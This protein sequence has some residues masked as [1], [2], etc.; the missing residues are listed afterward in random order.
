MDKYKHL[1]YNE[2]TSKYKLLALD[3]DGT[4]TRNDKTISTQTLK[5]LIRAQEQGMRIVLVSGRPTCGVVSLA[6]QL[7]L[8]R[9]D[10][11]IIS[12]NGGQIFS[13]GEGRKV[14]S[15]MLPKEEIP[16]LYECS[17]N[18]P[19]LTIMTYCGDEIVTEV[20]EYPYVMRAAYINK[21]PI[22]QV[23][24]FLE[25]I[26]YELPK[27]QIVGEPE[28]LEPLEK[29]MQ[30]EVKGRLEVFRS[31]PF[32]LEIAPPG[33]D[34]AKSLEILL[35][36]LGMTRE[37]LVACGD[38]FNDITMIKYAGMGVA[39]RN[40]QQIVKDNADYITERTNEEDGVIE[41][42]EKFFTSSSS[43]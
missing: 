13:C 6:E 26:T 36:M 40:G 20:A 10:G 15:Q 4:L 19:D 9:F 28:L 29:K 33:I 1:A 27:C 43:F 38:G 37:E 24:N 16:Y 2:L 30:A 12:F 21:V 39:M 32:F 14:Y 42:V 23:P 22:R 25:E 18:H 41:V 11:Y 8:Q 3:L 34:K 7:Q 31:E 5:T 17:K 35:S